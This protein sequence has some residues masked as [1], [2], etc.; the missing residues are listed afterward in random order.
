MQRV[1]RKQIVPKNTSLTLACKRVKR[2]GDGRKHA[3]SRVGRLRAMA[4]SNPAA[5]GAR[6]IASYFK[7]PVRPAKSSDDDDD[8]YTVHTDGDTTSKEGM[9]DGEDEEEINAL[10]EG[11]VSDGEESDAP[12]KITK[13]S[14]KRAP[15]GVVSGGSRAATSDNAPQF[16]SLP[17]ISDIPSMFKDIVNRVPQLN[18]LAEKIQGR[19]LRVATMC[20]GTESPLLALGLISRA[21]KEEHG[22][23]LE[24]EHVFSCEIEPFKQ[25]YIERNFH[26][27]ILF[28]DV[29]ELGADEA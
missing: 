20:S 25:A 9:D 2:S 8:E 5:K 10:S 16:S 17:P 11:V 18:E 23:K 13:P 22:V 12:V 3:Y 19:A 29:C 4:K 21:L 27:P 28:R 14:A 7:K 24:I 1:R 15:K 6:D 26:P